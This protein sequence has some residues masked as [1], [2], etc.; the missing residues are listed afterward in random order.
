MEPPFRH[1]VPDSFPVICSVPVNRPVYDKKIPDEPMLGLLPSCDIKEFDIYGP[2]VWNDTAYATSFEKFWYAKPIDFFSAYPELCKFADKCFKLHYNFLQDSRVIHITATEKNLDSTPA[3]PKFNDFATEREYLEQY[4]WGP[5]IAEFARIDRGARPRVLWYLFLKK[6]I[7]KQDK[8]DKGDIRQI[9][10]SDPIY[11]RIG[12]C[13]ENHQN[14]LM[15]ENTHRS[16]GQCGWSPF[17]GGFRDVMLRLNSKAGWFVEFDW[18]RFDGTIPP[19]LFKHIKMLRW[20]FINKKQRERYR[21]MYEWYVDNLIHRA[22]LL[23]SGEVTK[24]TRG[25]PSGQISTTMDNNMINYWLQAF[26]FAWFF[27]PDYDLFDKFDTVVYGDDRLSRFPKLPRN[28]VQDVVRMYEKVF[29][30][31]VKPEKIKV[32]TELAGLTFCGFKI[33]S[34]LMPEPVEPYKLMAGLMKPSSTLPDYEALHG[35]LLSYQI[36]LHFCDDDH[37]FK[38]YIEHCLATTSKLVVDL[39]KR[40]T[41]E[42]LDRLWRGGPKQAANG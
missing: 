41:K 37:P 27:G 31:W 17:Y 16:S 42:Q 15:K 34:D 26:E 7:L 30:M 11:A 24:H 6:E 28:Y 14:N 2:T 40:F 36:L 20:D 25:N 13:F 35:K 22:V 3:Y 18:T 5:Y 21:S 38:R 29:G 1:L 19:A 12:A 32:S 39:P 4:G 23:P 10:C 9:L 33:K 8:I